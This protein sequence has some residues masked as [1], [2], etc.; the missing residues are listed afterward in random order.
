MQKNSA[1]RRNW[2]FILSGLIDFLTGSVL[3]LIWLGILPLNLDEFGITRNWVGL[4]GAFL[5]VSGV[6]VVSY[7]LTRI[8][9]PAE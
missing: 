2:I 7:L 9:E 4:I 8:R 3:L 6:V 1:Q 5:A